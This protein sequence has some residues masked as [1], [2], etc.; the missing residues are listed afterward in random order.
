MSLALIPVGEIG[1][2]SGGLGGLRSG[3]GLELELELE[4]RHHSD[5]EDGRAGR[6]G[7]GRG[8]DQYVRATE[9]SARDQEWNLELTV[10]SSN[11]NDLVGQGIAKGVVVVDVPEVGGTEVSGMVPEVVHPPGTMLTLQR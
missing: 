8:M 6:V 7:C 1:S 11:A 9:F 2:A 10:Q 5:I 3:G 4:Q